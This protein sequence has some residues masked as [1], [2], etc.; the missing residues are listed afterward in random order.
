MH[1]DLSIDPIGNHADDVV[2]A[3]N[4]AEQCGYHGV[5]LPDELCDITGA[6]TW[7]H[8]PWTLISAI[9]ARTTRVQIG[10]MVLNIANRDKMAIVRIAAAIYDLNMP[11]DLDIVLPNAK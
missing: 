7:S 6:G 4:A 1:I 5:L 3:A 8:D 11:D 2:S 10:S 9:A